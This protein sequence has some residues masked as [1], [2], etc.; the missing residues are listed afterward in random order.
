MAT[1]L[2]VG[3]ISFNT[4]E[5]SLET[6]FAEY[7]TVESCSIAKD[8]DTGRSRGFAFVELDSEE[9]ANKAIAA[10]DGKTFEDREI[11]VNIAKPREDRPARRDDGGFRGGY[12]RR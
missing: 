11:V 3:K 1:K 6:L 2:F 4:T 10:L 7:G 12:N 5:Q 8:R 9:A